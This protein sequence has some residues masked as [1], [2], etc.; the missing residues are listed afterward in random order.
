MYSSYMSSVSYEYRCPYGHSGPYS[1]PLHHP[2]PSLQKSHCGW[3]KRNPPYSGQVVPSTNSHTLHCTPRGYTSSLAR[4]ITKPISATCTNFLS[5]FSKLRLRKSSYCKNEYTPSLLP[6]ETTSPTSGH[7]SLHY[8]STP[9]SSSDEFLHP[10]VYPKYHWAY[11]KP[12][13]SRYPISL[14]KGE[15]RC[16]TGQSYCPSGGHSALKHTS[17]SVLATSPPFRTYLAK[18]SLS[19]NYAS[20]WGDR[21][22]L[23]SHSGIQARVRSRHTPACAPLDCPLHYPTPVTRV[24]DPSPF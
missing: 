10:P 19:R 15:P 2:T 16:G 12:S 13:H 14:S 5:R 1:P 22:D 21:E 20:A 11:S 8:S 9:S 24:P 7:C 17:R 3:L 18:K 4:T 23:P 6:F